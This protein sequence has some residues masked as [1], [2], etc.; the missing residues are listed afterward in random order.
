[1]TYR[2]GRWWL[3]GALAV[4]L[5]ASV[6]TS[7]PA[8]F[9]E[10]EVEFSGV[11]VGEEVVQRFT[12]SSHVEDS[13]EERLHGRCC[14]AEGSPPA[15]L[16]VEFFD[17]EQEQEDESGGARQ[18]VNRRTVGLDGRR[19]VGEELP[20]NCAAKG[21]ERTLAVR[22]LHESS[23]DTGAEPVD[24]T[25]YVDGRVRYHSP[26]IGCQPKTRE[27]TIAAHGAGLERR[28]STP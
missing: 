13:F 25:L 7:P 2:T 15:S 17:I 14:V 27:F 6:A 10:A 22:C 16:R 18:L 28:L 21:C 12:L 26:L 23:P 11:A 4:G 1:M 5:L 24:L 20:L 8:V 19:C 3:L 9:D